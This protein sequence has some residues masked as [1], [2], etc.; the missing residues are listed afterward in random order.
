M[1][2]PKR[3]VV[4]VLSMGDAN[5]G[6]ELADALIDEHSVAVQA[7]RAPP[8]VHALG[9]SAKPVPLLDDHGDGLECGSVAFTD[10]L[11]TFVGGLG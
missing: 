6:P 1:L 3:P 10:L 2:I 9:L 8:L 11:K 5:F 7:V 4:G